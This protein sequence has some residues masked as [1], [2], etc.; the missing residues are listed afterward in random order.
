MG[1]D[2]TCV[3]VEKRF[4]DLIKFR[5]QGIKNQITFFQQDML[6]FSEF[7]DKKYDAEIFYESFH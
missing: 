1:H 6:E 3:E 5:T 7:P 2:V 4:I